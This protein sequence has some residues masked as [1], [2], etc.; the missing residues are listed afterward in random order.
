MS[1]RDRPSRSE[2]TAVIAA[3]LA[4]HAMLGALI[5]SGRGPAVPGAREE[6]TVLLD[7]RQPP[8][9]PPPP[10]AERAADKEEGAAGLRAEAS[11]VVA[12]PPRIALPAPSPV[13]AAPVV[14]T[15]SATSS[16]AADRGGGPGAGGAGSGAGGGGS[17]GGGIGS[18]ARLLSGGLTRSDYRR[19]RPFDLASGRARL[20]LMVGTDGRVG[21]CRAENSSG[22]AAIDSALCGLLQSRTRWSPARDTAGNPIAVRVYY[23]ATWEQY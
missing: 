5:L 9:P 23:V 17:G 12:P 2:R 13:V 15:G 20:A 6:R 8:P 14:G 16:G 19:F 22:S 11:P 7:I 18:E 10:P 1:Y 4:I 21:T 3:V